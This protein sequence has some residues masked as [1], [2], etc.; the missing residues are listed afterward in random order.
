MTLQRRGPERRRRT[1]TAEANSQKRKKERNVRRQKREKSFPQPRCKV[2]LPPPS[3]F[4]LPGKSRA[5]CAAQ[6]RRRTEKKG[7]GFFFLWRVPF[8]SGGQAHM[9][10]GGGWGGDASPLAFKNLSPPLEL[11]IRDLQK[12][13]WPKTGESEFFLKKSLF[14]DFCTE[15]PDPYFV[16]KSFL[17]LILF[18]IKIPVSFYKNLVCPPPVPPSTPPLQREKVSPPLGPFWGVL[19]IL[20]YSSPPLEKSRRPC[21]LTVPS[22]VPSYRHS[23]YDRAAASIPFAPLFP[24]VRTTQR[25]AQ[26]FSPE[27]F[28]FCLFISFIPPLG[29]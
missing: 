26:F 9:G 20:R 15:S 16:K 28:L 4:S 8:R 1:K 14:C 12:N 5:I 11:K 24:H 21:V 2:P 27:L 25:A 17:F 18:L 3:H 23:L 7:R 13:F 10:E 6:R 22:A 29:S 19:Q